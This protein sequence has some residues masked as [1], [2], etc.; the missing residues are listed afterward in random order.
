MQLEAMEHY[1]LTKSFSHADF[2]KPKT[3]AEF[4]TN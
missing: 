2:L 4:S 1:G 3:N